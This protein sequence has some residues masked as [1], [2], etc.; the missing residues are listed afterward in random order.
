MAKKR[1]INQ[2]TPEGR[3]EIHSNLGI[4]MKLMTALMRQPLRNRSVEYADNRI[5]LF[6]AQYGKCAI[7]GTEFLSTD[8]IHCHHKM[9][10][11]MGGTDKYKNLILVLEP[12]H[13]LI[14][15][16]DLTVIDKY[17]KLLN[18]D[19]PQMKKLNELRK[20]AGNKAI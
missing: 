5:S 14:H 2:Y 13:K 15:A 3:K 11:S 9:P 7:T 18:L 6:S 1:S 12:V 19:K 4:N 17:L 16:T 8:D 10:R 20:M